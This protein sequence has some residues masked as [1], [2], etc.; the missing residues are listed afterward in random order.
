[1]NDQAYRLLFW[2]LLSV[3]LVLWVGGLIRKAID[4]ARKDHKAD[5]EQL[6]DLIEAVTELE[7]CLHLIRQSVSA[8]DPAELISALNGH[9]RALASATPALESVKPSVDEVARA[10]KAMADQV[11]ILRAVVYGGR[12]AEDF[13]VTAD[14]P[15]AIQ[16]GEMAEDIDNLIRDHGLSRAQAEMRVRDMYSHRSMR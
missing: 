5:R 8:A 12:R 2:I 10:A 6:G 7:K 9:A 16:R 11:A 1:M 14:D 4:R 13:P 3:G 15:A